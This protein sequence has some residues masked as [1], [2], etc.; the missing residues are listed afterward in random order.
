MRLQQVFS[1]PWQIA[2][3]LETAR[4]LDDLDSFRAAVARHPAQAHPGLG[5]AV[6]DVARDFASR[7]IL[8]V[9]PLQGDRI[10]FAGQQPYVDYYPA[11][12]AKLDA[13]EA[14]GGSAFFALADHAPLGSDPWLARTE[15]PCARA[16]GGML[17]FHFHRPLRSHEGKDLRFVPPPEPA[18]LADLTEKL[19]RMITL[20]AK[21]L[22]ADAFDRR[23]AFDRLRRLGI[24]LEKARR[25]ARSA[26]DFNS[27]WSARLFARLGFRLPL[28]PL[29]AL[30]SHDEILPRVADTLAAFVERQALFAESME[31][32]LRLAGVRE[33]GWSPKEPGHVPLA[34]ADPRS[35]L[36]HAMRLERRG[37]DAWLVAAHGGSEAF[38]VGRADAVGVEELLRRLAGRWSLDVFAP[39]FLFR[40][41]VAGIVNGRGSIRYSLMLAHVY[42]RLFGEPH[43]PNLLAS[44]NPVLTGPFAEAV[45]R[46]HGGLPAA[47]DGCEPTLIPRLLASDEPEIRAEIAACWRTNGDRP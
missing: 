37:A 6:L 38:N 15:M 19:K 8:P 21:E 44:C 25:R 42:A 27:L 2:P 13:L 24:D 12:L 43:P 7:A 14:C 1:Q 40:L 22:P 47:L 39:L 41:G 9:Y 23:A 17:R 26:A 32:A 20:T 45:R 5:P 30:L 36:R 28:L 35:G 18:V 11:V 4:A 29:C 10:C 34:V 33:L 31:E 16:A 3:L 46:E